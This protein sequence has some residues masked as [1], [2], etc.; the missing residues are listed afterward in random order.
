MNV[1]TSFSESNKYFTDYNADGF[2]DIVSP[3]PFGA[4]VEFGH[5]DE[6]GE[7]HFSSNSLITYSTVIKGE[8]PIVPEKEV[9]Y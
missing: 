4:V 8:V 1:N 9:S 5:I 6:K 2:L 3:T 7:L